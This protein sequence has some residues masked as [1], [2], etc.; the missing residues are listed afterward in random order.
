[1]LEN[2][3][4]N[5]NLVS[6]C[7]VCPASPHP[8]PPGP[9]CIAFKGS[10]SLANPAHARTKAD[11]ALS[12]STPRLPRG[13]GLFPG[14]VCHHPGNIHPKPK[15]GLSLHKVWSGE[16]AETL[17]SPWADTALLMGHIYVEKLRQLFIR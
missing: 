15:L 17:P 9:G 12:H 11:Q 10:T 4:V 16:D 1:M 5:Q 8:H 6:L 13:G 7:H 14:H 2:S 3:Y